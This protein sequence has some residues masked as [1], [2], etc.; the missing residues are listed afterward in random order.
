[1]E[2]ICKYCQKPF[3]AT[4]KTAI[5]CSQNHR[6]MAHMELQKSLGK[7][8]PKKTKVKVAELAATV[9]CSV[10]ADLPK[11]E[12]SADSIVDE[13]IGRM[14]VDFCNKNNCTWDDV[15]AAYLASL[16]PIKPKA[17]KVEALVQQKPKSSGG[18]YDRRA[19]KLG[20]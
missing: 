11:P 14:V 17:E 7:S 10:A 15:S 8:K 6:V 20:F 9:G 3:E 2:K 12:R 13:K 4:R 18:G 1:M 19:S 5:F 16:K